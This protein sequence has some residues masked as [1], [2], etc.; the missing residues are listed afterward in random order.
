V[1]LWS[2]SHIDLAWAREGA[3]ILSPAPPPPS[4]HPAKP[5]WIAFLRAAAA[6]ADADAVARR[7]VIVQTVLVWLSVAGTSWFL[8]RRTSFARGAVLYAVLVLFLR[9]PDSATSVMSEALTAALFLPIVASLLDPPARISRGIL[10]GAATALLFLLRP[11]A[12]AAAAALAILAFASTRRWRALAGFAAVAVLLI[13]PV[14]VL[15]SPPDRDAMRGLGPAF[16][17]ARA[18]YGWTNAAGLAPPDASDAA[19]LRVWRLFHGILGSEYHDASWSPV[20]SFLDEW[21]RTLSPFLVLAT[22][23]CLLPL[24]RGRER[25]AR[26]LGLALGALLIAQSYLLGALPRFALPFLPALFLC[27]IAAWPPARSVTLAV[28]AA[29][30]LGARWQRH[31]L[32]REWGRIEAPG[33][34]ITQTISRGALPAAPPAVLALRVAPA[35]VPSSAG[36]SVLGPGG[37]V[38]YDSRSDD[39]ERR[40]PYVAM[41]LPAPILQAN[42]RGDVS[43]TLVSQG[44]YGDTQYLLFPVIPPPWGPPARREGGGPLSPSTGIRSGGLDWWAREGAP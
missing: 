16:V 15:T 42:R 34:R 4:P 6:G 13:L 40:R 28:F 5:A 8:A 22:L 9:L 19:R 36:L 3:G 27:A 29:L 23:S 1:V 31:V 17:W 43:V 38:L 12:G 44:A 37:E 11:N 18:E 41:A 24:P 26:L 2:D 20:W 21:S 14:W 39:I 10:L 33:I 25:L 30:L 35:L 32:D 7:V